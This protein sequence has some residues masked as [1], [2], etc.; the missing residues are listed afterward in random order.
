[1]T[2]RD[3]MKAPGMR[4]ALALLA[5]AFV[6]TG[7]ATVNAYRVD[8]GAKPPAASPLTKVGLVPPQPVSPVDVGSLVET[9]PFAPNRTAPKKRYRLPGDTD[10]TAK[11]VAV[12]GTREPPKPVVLGVAPSNTQDSTKSFA[13]LQLAGQTKIVHAGQKIGEFTVI[14]IQLHKV[15]FLN[16]AGQQVEVIYR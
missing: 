1:M 14:S 12:A 5:L 9:D 4:Y 13:T 11:P 15:V 2:A 8:T 7:W 16:A 3:F 10:I 6:T